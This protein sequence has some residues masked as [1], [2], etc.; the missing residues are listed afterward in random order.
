MTWFAE[1]PVTGA[2]LDDGAPGGQPPTL[3][4][5]LRNAPWNIRVRVPCL[6]SPLPTAGRGCTATQIYPAGIAVS[7]SLMP[8]GTRP[9]LEL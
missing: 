3:W 4:G 9:D 6:L 1:D 8:G 5:A 2:G 7:P